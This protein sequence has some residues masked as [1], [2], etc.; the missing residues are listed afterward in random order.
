MEVRERERDPNHRRGVERGHRFVLWLWPLLCRPGAHLKEEGE[1]EES[2]FFLNLSAQSSANT[3][4][5]GPG[6]NIRII[7]QTPALA[8][9]GSSLLGSFYSSPREREREEEEEGVPFFF[10][11]SSHKLAP[12]SLP[13]LS[14]TNTSNVWLSISKQ[15]KGRGCYYLRPRPV[16]TIFFH[17]PSPPPPKRRRRRRGRGRTG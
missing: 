10:S 4:L 2:R 16:I 11:F 5:T 7:S 1:G 12:S 17:P 13:L 9:A 3:V 14:R 6:N 8:G 15:G